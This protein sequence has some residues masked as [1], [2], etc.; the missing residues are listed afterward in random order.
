MPHTIDQ[1]DI[2]PGNFKKSFFLPL[3]LGALFFYVVLLPL[4]GVMGLNLLAVVEPYIQ[5]SFH[6][7]MFQMF[8]VF[9][10]RVFFLPFYV[11]I[12]FL[13]FRFLIDKLRG[14]ARSASNTRKSVAGEAAAAAEDKA[15]GGRF[16]GALATVWY[17]GSRFRYGAE[18]TIGRA[19]IALSEIRSRLRKSVPRNLEWLTRPLYLIG[20]Y[21]LLFWKYLYLGACWAFVSIEAFFF[22]IMVANM[23]ARPTT[24]QVFFVRCTQ[25]HSL[26]RPMN[27]NHSTRVW[28]MTIARMFRHAKDLDKTL[29]ADKKDAVIDLLVSIRGYSDKRLI[30]SKCY[31]CHFPSPIFNKKRTVEEWNLLVDRVQRQ[32]TFYITERQRDQIQKY[33]ASRSDLIA[34]KPDDVWNEQ[35]KMLF[36]RKC[37][38]CHT[39]DIVLMPEVGKSEW[40]QVLARMGD[41]EPDF[42]SVAESLSVLPVINTALADKKRFF[43]AFPHSRMREKPNENR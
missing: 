43:N 31:A 4:Q 9:A 35:A 14:K 20:R 11:Y 16:S 42:L 6:F 37:A 3:I 5:F 29:P 12:G 17:Q 32:N 28:E 27:F 40:P 13:L 21:F 41:K 39:L 2:T 38:A 19:G 8:M 23:A 24:T 18:R 15:D 10:A 33:L 22:V 34:A 36:E 7:R 26:S 1:S 25:C 30:H